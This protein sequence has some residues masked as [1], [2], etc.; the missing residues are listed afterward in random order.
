MLRHVGEPPT[1]PSRA[2]LQEGEHGFG[3]DGG[4]ILRRARRSAAERR[5]PAQHLPVDPQTIAEHPPVVPEPVVQF[6]TELFRGA[7][8]WW[9]WHRRGERADM[10]EVGGE[11]TRG[12]GQF[13]LHVGRTRPRACVGEFSHDVRIERAGPEAAGLRLRAQAADHEPE[14]LDGAYG[15]ALRGKRFQ[16]SC[17]GGGTASGNPSAGK[18]TGRVCTT[19]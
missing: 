6:G 2:T 19:P 15:V 11:A 9:C 12:H 10:N 14:A 13:A 16:E 3:R 4:Q 8:W 18:P 17:C 1:G 7:G 5:D